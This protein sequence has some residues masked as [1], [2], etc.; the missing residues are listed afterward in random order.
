MTDVRFPTYGY[1][2]SMTLLDRT[3]IRLPRAG[4]MACLGLYT[5]QL[6]SKEGVMGLERDSDEF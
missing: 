1:H 2:P 6:I 3:L 5:D 4:Q